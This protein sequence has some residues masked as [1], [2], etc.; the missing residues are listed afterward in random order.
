MATVV[1]ERDALMAAASARVVDVVTPGNVT[2]AALRGINLA[3]PASAFRVATNGAPTPSAITLTVTLK[4]IDV[5]TPVTWA[6]T[7]GS[8]TLTGTGLARTLSFANMSSDFVTITASVAVEG[9]TY[10]DTLS[11]MKLQDGSMGGAGPRGSLTVT[12]AITGSAWANAEALAALVAAGAESAIATDTCTLYNVSAKFSE[13]RRYDG[14]NWVP[15]GAS[16]PGSVLMPES[17]TTEKLVV[18]PQGIAIN[19]D[20][21]TQDITAWTGGGASIVTDNSA[22][23]GSSALQCTGQGTAV[24]SKKFPI[25]SSSAYRVRCWAKQQ[26]G[27]STMFLAV[28][29]YD[30]DGNLISG[31]TSPSGWADYGTYHY[32][33]LVGQT[34]PASWTE[35]SASFGSGETKG[36]PAAARFA[37]VGLIS[38][39]NAAGSQRIS[40]VLCHQKTTGEMVVDGSLK[41]RHIDSN[42][43]SVK[44]STGRVLLNAEGDAVPPW[45]TDLTTPNDR[46][47][48][49]L[50]PADVGT[51]TRQLR[52][53]I[54]GSGLVSTISPDGNYYTLSSVASEVSY[55]PGG[56]GVSS[57]TTQ[58]V[59]IVPT[60]PFS[61]DSE[62]ELEIWVG[63]QDGQGINFF[64][65]TSAQGGSYFSPGL[66]WG[67][68]LIEQE[69]PSTT[70]LSLVGATSRSFNDAYFNMQTPPPVETLSANR[71][72]SNQSGWYNL[73]ALQS[74]GWSRACQFKFR[75]RHTGLMVGMDLTSNFPRPAI[76]V[77]AGTIADGYDARVLESR[78]KVI[79]PRQSLAIT[80]AIK[81]SVPLAG[82]SSGGSLVYSIAADSTYDMFNL[83]IEFRPG[84]TYRVRL[85]KAKYA[86]QSRQA[87]G[88]GGIYYVDAPVNIV[89]LWTKE[90]NWSDNPGNFS[91]VE[92]GDLANIGFEVTNDSG[93]PSV[94][95]G[96][97]VTGLATTS[98]FNLS[99]TR[100][101][102]GSVRGGVGKFARA[103]FQLKVNLYAQGAASPNYVDTINVDLQVTG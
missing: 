61:L 29:F 98:V 64:F 103:K 15:V 80:A 73:P 32:Y 46:G 4:G 56:A 67:G 68:F 69:R 100:F 96:A 59:D 92:P 39:F 20:P 22:P 83:D 85:Y 91:G 13:M 8:A 76:R 38:N 35:Y 101:F 75:I 72:T 63:I 1:N 44:S 102:G 71:T 34:G 43:L 33:G 24:L 12:R 37:S 93:F 57:N 51:N 9:L 3:A 5:S 25:N 87:P 84:G 60:T 81:S 10:S 42:G 30:A 17:I 82:A 66:I 58:T 47:M 99:Q 65:E 41:A 2:P 95:G 97:E 45:L 16:V 70:G 50:K 62:I 23:N 79:R 52:T 40:G 49:L 21:N 48:S 86:T 6:V 19:P 89:D 26:S 78:I 74:S 11:F 94:S 88:E 18:A 7:V 36:I 27:T 54:P 28:A 77:Y 14:T 53:L 90:G 55:T 31:S